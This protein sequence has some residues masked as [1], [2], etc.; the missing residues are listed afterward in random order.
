MWCEAATEWLVPTNAPIAVFGKYSE[1]ANNQVSNLKQFLVVMFVIFMMT[2]LEAPLWA[3]WLVGMVVWGL[4][5]G[6]SE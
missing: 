1:G 4:L 3:T 2:I 6:K 5:P